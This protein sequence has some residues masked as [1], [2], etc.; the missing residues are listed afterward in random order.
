MQ[1]FFFSIVVEKN[2]EWEKK[3]RGR[4]NDLLKVA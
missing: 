4:M 2:P 3:W 1:S